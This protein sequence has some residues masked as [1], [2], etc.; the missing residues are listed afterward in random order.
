MNLRNGK[1]IGGTFRG[2]PKK[3]GSIGVVGDFLK[4]CVA[5]IEMNP[6]GFTV[7]DVPIALKRQGVEPDH[8]EG[9]VTGVAVLSTSHLA[10]HTWPEESGATFD[11]HSCRD[12]PAEKVAELLGKFFDA[13]DVEIHDLTFS[14]HPHEVREAV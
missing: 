8:D 14:L 11:L 10:I 13:Y 12:F 7:Y 2:N 3:L 4:T 6:I 9:G 5:S 1:K